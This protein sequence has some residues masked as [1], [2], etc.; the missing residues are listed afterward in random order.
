M[1]GI[2]LH[3]S[4]IAAEK[5][6]A[7]DVFCSFAMTAEIFARRGTLPPDK[8]KFALGACYDVNARKS[9]KR[10]TSPRCT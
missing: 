7:L 5:L 8:E 1:F 2:S 6:S 10:A 3:F 4:M 9:W